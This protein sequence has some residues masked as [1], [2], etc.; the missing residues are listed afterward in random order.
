[1]KYKRYKSTVIL[2]EYVANQVLLL[3]FL[4]NSLFVYLYSITTFIFFSGYL[5]D[6]N[7]IRKYNFKDLKGKMSTFLR[8]WHLFENNTCLYCLS[9]FLSFCR[10]L[11]L[12]PSLFFCSFISL[13]I[14]I[15]IAIS[16]SMF[17]CLLSISVSPFSFSLYY[18]FEL[19]V[20]IYSIYM[21]F[22]LSLSIYVSIP[23]SIALKGVRCPLLLYVRILLILKCWL[24]QGFL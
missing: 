18:C 2:G 22:G 11:R 10:H 23:L 24:N 12:T 19:Y 7:V 5:Y 9:V 21:F 17:L 6:D 8:L 13:S 16:L 15:Y 20:Y 1:M 4:L 14:S 3:Y